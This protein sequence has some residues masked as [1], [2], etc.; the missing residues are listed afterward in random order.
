[1]LRIIISITCASVSERDR[2]LA[3]WFPCTQKSACRCWQ[4]E[5]NKKGER[6]HQILQRPIGEATQPKLLS[7]L[8]CETAAAFKAVLRRDWQQLQIPLSFPLSLSL[9]LSLP[10]SLSLSLSLSLPLS[11]SLSPSLPLSLSRFGESH[12]L[13]NHEKGVKP[14]PPYLHLPLLRERHLAPAR[15][16]AVVVYFEWCAIMTVQQINA[17]QVC[18]KWWNFRVIPCKLLI[19]SGGSCNTEA[20]STSLTHSNLTVALLCQNVWQPALL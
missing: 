10:L 9:S 14:S 6:T 15:G 2:L 4:W 8:S 3:L 7:L 16:E 18:G 20:C 12:S 5:V 13:G 11:L 17:T 1:M 19:L